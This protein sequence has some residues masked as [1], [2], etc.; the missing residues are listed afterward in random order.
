MICAPG[1]LRGHI[2]EIVAR[3]PFR[4]FWGGSLLVNAHGAGIDH[5]HLAV[6]SL[7]DG[8][9]Q[10]VSHARFPPAIEAV[11]IVVEGPVRSG[12][13]SSSLQSLNH[14]SPDLPTVYEYA[15]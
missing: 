8:I 13:W 2:S 15:A 14:L 5:L 4:V 1:G 3:V 11:V 9:H 6:M 10:F 7:D 12:P